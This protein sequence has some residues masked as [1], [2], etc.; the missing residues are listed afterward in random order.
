L[1]EEREKRKAEAKRAADLEKKLAYLEGQAQARATSAEPKKP[2]TREEIEAQ[3]FQ[4]P[5]DYINSRVQDALRQ[6]ETQ[7]MQQNINRSEAV[8][9]SKWSDYDEMVGVFADMVRQQPAL[10]AELRQQHDPATYAYQRAKLYRELRA[11]GGSIE[12][13]RAKVEAEVR[14]KVEEEMK[15]RTAVTTAAGVPKSSAGV[16]GTGAQKSS[17]GGDYSLSGLLGKR[18]F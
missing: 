10:A 13:L 4:N 1:K 16:A 3:F 14:A 5:T 6:V 15:R 18:G 12:K 2:L 11:T 9:R 17:A 7:T 8:A